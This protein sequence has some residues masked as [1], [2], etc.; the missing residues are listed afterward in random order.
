MSAR[1][2]LIPL[3]LVGITLVTFLLMHLAPGDPAALRAGQGRGVTAETIAQYRQTFG[4]DRP[5]GAR[6]LAWLGKSVRL[7]FGSSL[8]D[9]RPVREKMLSALPRTLALALL[10]T[11]FAYLVAVPLGAFSAARDGRRSTRILAAGLY[12]IYALPLAAVALIALRAGAPYGGTPLAFVAAAACLALAALVRLSRHQRAALLTALR[13]DY[14]RTARAVGAS[15]G[16]VLFRHALPNALLPMV[17]LLAAELPALLSGSVLVEEVFGIRGLGLLGFDAVLGR[18]YPT[19][20]GL[21]VLGAVL[22]LAGVLV[23]DVAYGLL[24]PRLREAP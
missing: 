17:T 14:V 20:L 21:T 3:T 9:G 10:A 2:A 19:L 12:V 4:L 8:V 11:F 13:A 7:D 16:R 6:Y 5:I 23:A 18:D 15:D 24:D 1:L 22:T